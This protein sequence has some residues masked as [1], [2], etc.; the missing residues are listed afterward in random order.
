MRSVAIKIVFWFFFARYLTRVIGSNYYSVPIINV[1]Y[2]PY[3]YIAG[4]YAFIITYLLLVYPLKRIEK[5]IHRFRSGNFEARILMKRKD[6]LGNIASAFDD[7]ADRIQVM[8]NSERRMTA[9]LGHE[10]RTPLTRVMLH[11]HN[12]KDNVDVEKSIELIEIEIHE[13]SSVSNKLL[14][15]AQIERGEIKPIIESFD[16]FDFISKI[17]RKMSLIADKNNCAIEFQSAGRF[18][19]ETDRSLLE[20]A[21]SN[22]ID[23]AIHYTTPYSTIQILLDLPTKPDDSLQIIVRDQGAGVPDELIHRIF[24]PF[25]R[26]EESRD[27]TTG[28]TGLGLAICKSIVNNLGGT[29]EARNLKPGFD[30]CIR[31]RAY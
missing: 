30:I 16:L 20:I 7:M 4:I 24:L 27:R 17:I 8:I 31:L 5:V 25:E 13:L 3:P 19:I 26:V 15:L 9:N 14:R 11:L 1:F 29:I 12:L 28:G 10:I 22:I 23:N 18:S 6:E 2:Y 21:L